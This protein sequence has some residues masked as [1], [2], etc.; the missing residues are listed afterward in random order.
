MKIM[1]SLFLIFLS[2][3][4]FS[5]E[6]AKESSFTEFF[7][8]SKIGDY[9]KVK[10]LIEKNP[11]VINEQ[12]DQGYTALIMAAYYGQEKVVDL[13]IKKGADVCLKDAKG[14][15]ATM[16]AI[17][18]GNLKIAKRLMNTKCAI[19]QVNHAGQTPLMYAALFGRIE[20]AKYL[21]EKG[22]DPNQEDLMGFSAM[23]LALMQG[24]D[25]LINIFKEFENY[26]KKLKKSAERHYTLEKNIYL[27][28]YESFM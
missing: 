23:S 20:I 15:T 21:L 16:G 5:Y 14:N 3:N 7:N 27:K 12:D 11:A 9:E 4:S 1:M 25:E 17:F 13:L 28:S 24:H 8:A 22:E 19:K 26:P 10:K 6:K 2:F 18:K